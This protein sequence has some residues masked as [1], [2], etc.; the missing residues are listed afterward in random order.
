MRATAAKYEEVA[1]MQEFRSRSISAAARASVLKPWVRPGVKVGGGH[2]QQNNRCHFPKPKKGANPKRIVLRQRRKNATQR[3]FKRRPFL[4][5]LIKGM[6]KAEPAYSTVGK[7]STERPTAA[8]HWGVRQVEASHSPKYQ[9]ISLLLGLHGSW[10]IKLNALPGVNASSLSCFEGVVA[11]AATD[12]SVTCEELS[13]RPGLSLLS[14]FHFGFH[15]VILE[16]FVPPSAAA[17]SLGLLWNL[18]ALN[19]WTIV[20]PLLSLIVWLRWNN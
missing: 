18:R 11:A 3:T 9:H 8:L 2:F 17:V 20:P 15:K 6:F 7:P 10:R 4:P 19:S 12:P 1:G 16:I 5:K 14:W 13:L